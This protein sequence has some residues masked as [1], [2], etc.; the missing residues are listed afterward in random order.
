VEQIATIGQPSQAA[1][2][3]DP[4][5]M[6]MLDLLKEPDSASGVARRMNLPRQKANYHLKELE[7]H[8]LV[9]FLEARKKGNCMERIVQATARHYLIDPSVFGKFPKLQDRFSSDYLIAS[10]GCAITEVA[11][12]SARARAVQQKLATMTMTTEIRFRSAVERNTFAFEHLSL[13]ARLVAKYHDTKCA[14]GRRF[15]V[16]AAFYPALGDKNNEDTSA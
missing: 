13:M 16:L 6:R 1:S 10:A 8:G 5:R 4:V 15:K 3:L 9:T 12:L 11:E 14:G 7:K 2:L